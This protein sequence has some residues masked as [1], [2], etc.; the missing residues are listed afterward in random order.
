MQKQQGGCSSKIWCQGKRNLKVVL[1]ESRIWKFPGN[2]QKEEAAWQWKKD[3]F[4]WAWRKNAGM[5]SQYEVTIATKRYLSRISEQLMAGWLTLWSTGI[6]WL[7][8]SQHD[9]GDLVYCVISFILSMWC[10][11]HSKKCVPANVGDAT[12]FRPPILCTEASCLGNI[13][14]PLDEWR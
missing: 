14:M 11:F 8:F 7:S 4:S 1:K 12:Y 10:K 2:K 13:Q 3:S 5:D 6:G 9:P